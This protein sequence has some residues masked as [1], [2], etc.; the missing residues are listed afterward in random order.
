MEKLLKKMLILCILII[1]LIVSILT[2]REILLK[3]KE[4][5][6]EYKVTASERETFGEI[7]SITSREEYFMVVE[8][9]NTYINAI[10]NNNDMLLYNIL[11][12]QV[13]DKYDL[14]VNNIN[15]MRD[16]DSNSKYKIKK[17]D[18]NMI[19]FIDTNYYIYG[20]IEDVERKS[21]TNYNMIVR[22]NFDTSTFSII[23]N[24]YLENTD[25]MNVDIENTKIETNKYNQ[26]V[27]RDYIT[28]EE[29]IKMYLE[30]YI[31]LAIEEPEE[32]YEMLDT[33]SKNKYF[34]NIDVYKKYVEEKLKKMQTFTISSCEVNNFENYN[35]YICI[36][37]YGNKYIFKERYIN[38]YSVYL[39][40]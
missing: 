14:K 26:Y 21:K 40:P 2:I 10:K 38:D 36:D 31:T 12:K 27:L 8:C 29:M 18:A 3:K 28:D 22:R 33:E 5:N 20:E 17:I 37:N 39:E 34:T 6:S 32:A 1:I 11:D 15:L 7:L 35:E 13:I 23:P 9:V 4:E 16:I 30:D 24:K 25:L 19:S